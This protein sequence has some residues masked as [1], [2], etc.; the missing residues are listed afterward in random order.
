MPLASSLQSKALAHSTA[1]GQQHIPSET[2]CRLSKS[3]KNAP[4]E[5]RRGTCLGPPRSDSQPK[6]T[7][8]AAARAS[9]THTAAASSSS[10]KSEHKISNQDKF[11]KGQRR[12]V[13]D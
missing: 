13:G 11:H 5:S 10:Q 3:T 1:T 9:A 2:C 7:T 6:R 12:C 8:S 4:E